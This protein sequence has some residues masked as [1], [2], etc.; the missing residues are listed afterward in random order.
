VSWETVP[1]GDLVRPIGRSGPTGDLETFTYVDLSSIDAR[2]KAITKPSRVA[3]EAAPSRARQNLRE[4]DVL[5]STVRPNLNGV[6]FVPADLDGAIAS[7]GFAVLR[8]NA[9]RLHPRFL[10]HWVQSAPFI[11]SMTSLAT[12]ASYPAVTDA[13][14]KASRIPLPPLA[15]QRRIAAIL[16]EA[17]AL[18]PVQRRRVSS[19]QELATEIYRDLV[20]QAPV[21]PLGD[22]A[23]MYGG[24]TL[25]ESAP[26]RGQHDGYLHLKV[27]DLNRPE[28]SRAVAVSGSWSATPGSRASTAPASS[29]IIPKRGGAIG[30]NKKRILAR[31]AVLDPNLMAVEGDE[32]QILP[33]V[34]FAWFDQ[35]DLRT[36]QSGSS[37]PQL[38]KKDLAP[39]LIPTPSMHDQQR[40]AAEVRRLESQLAYEADVA[41]KLDALFASVQ[42]RAF[43]GEL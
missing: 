10:F 15:E 36:I 4:S 33:A 31:P 29:I 22:I 3:F 23:R 27:S 35:L 11:E 7:T 18:R 24:G 2:S 37:V 28:N 6:A 32:A 34:L 20:E 9:T 14:V 16:D 38:N 26:Y 17:G 30:T 25:P 13:I 43:R 41:V 39:L 1:L 5:V 21:Q 12:G 42:H 8:A 40:F 19:I